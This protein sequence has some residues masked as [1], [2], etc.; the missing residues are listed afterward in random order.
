VIEEDPNTEPA[1]KLPVIWP[2]IVLIGMLFAAAAGV[3]I[4]IVVS[5]MG[6]QESETPVP[7]FNPSVSPSETQT[8]EPA[9]TV[10]VL[11]TDIIGKNVA[12]VSILLKERGLLVDAIPG[13][14]LDPA[15]PR[16]LTVYRADGLGQVPLGSVVK[17][18]Y[19][20]QQTLLPTPTESTPTTE[21]TEDQSPDPSVPTPSPTG[22]TESGN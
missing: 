5:L 6:E 15:D 7:T 16:I 2:W 14:P 4:A 12:D 3:M 19:Y 17:V 22:D 18:Y 9:A 13:E 11:L 10:V 1:E 21:P 20:I 8:E